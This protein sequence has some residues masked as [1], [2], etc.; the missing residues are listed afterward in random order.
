MQH[1]Q[2]IR[3]ARARRARHV[4]ELAEFIRIPSVSAQPA[5]A[6][7][8]RCAA[9]WLARHLRRMGMPR[10]RVFA[11]R[12]A[13]VVY[14]HWLA[15]PGAPTVLIY[16]HYD[17]QPAEP[18]SA[19]AIPPFSGEV[20]GGFIHGRGASDNKGQLF[21][22]LSAVESY[23]RA[24][25]LPVNV[26]MLF[27]G[28]E[29][30][31][32][33]TLRRFVRRHR[34]P[35][36]ADVAVMSD[37]R[38]LAPDRPVITY[39]LRG[40]LGVNL[41]VFGPPRPLHSGNFGGAVADPA[42]A[43]SRIVASLHDRS[44]RIAIPGFYRGVRPLSPGTRERFRSDGPSDEQVLADAGVRRGSGEAGFSAYERI[45]ARPALVIQRLSAGHQ[46]P[47]AHSIIPSRAA[48]Q[49]R[50]RLAP[51]QTPGE[52]ERLLRDH[53]ARVTPAG[54]R[55][56]LGVFLRS[57]P[58]LLDPR[59]PAFE[60]A[61]EALRRGFGRR[62]LFLRSGGSIPIVAAFREHLG[63]PTVLMGFA[64]ASD[65]AHGPNER[66]SLDRFG[67]GVETSIAFLAEIGR[68]RGDGLRPWWGRREKASISFAGA[69]P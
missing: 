60:A 17:V 63:V 55:V 5:H 59:H 61:A 20:R 7:D 14:A 36:R 69:A 21:C 16:G 50:F 23:L 39:G 64:L 27:D 46:G 6:E 57:D 65:R 11:R 9:A 29:E 25:G 37:T 58:V 54:V 51:D 48:A 44:G 31:G 53:V 62:P 52:A 12:G 1:A 56:E 3:H 35:L 42:Q 13:P 38:I 45:V 24:G 30:N 15:A 34:V 4:R 28:E 67:R 40:G 26:K 66:F 41:R 8:V 32:S 68:N 33:P 10:V 43:L 19:W 18:A 47:G 22:H 2:A 49:L